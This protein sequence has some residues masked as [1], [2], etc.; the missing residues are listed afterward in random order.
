MSFSQ[1]SRK[2]RA[3]ASPLVS[4]ARRSSS[5]TVRPNSCSVSMLRF[6]SALSSVVAN[7]A[8][9][10]LAF[11]RPAK[12]P[13]LAR[14]WWPMPRLGLVAARRN[15]GSSSLLTMRRSQAQRSRISARSKKLCPPETLYGMPA[16][17]S[18]CSNTR[19]W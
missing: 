1:P 6:G 14:V 18:A 3:A 9:N 17:R 16:L 13:R 19:A 8:S 5:F 10:R 4:R 15:A 2:A 7:R 11:Q 12:V